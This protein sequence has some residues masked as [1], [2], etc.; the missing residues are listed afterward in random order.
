MLTKVATKP[1][2]NFEDLIE[3]KN[4]LEHFEKTLSEE[5]NS[6]FLFCFLKIKKFNETSNKQNKI[7]L[8]T[9]IYNNYLHEKSLNCLN[10]MNKKKLNEKFTKASEIPYGEQSNIVNESLKEISTVLGY[11]F[12]QYKRTNEW[13]NY[14][15]TTYNL[16]SKPL[17][18]EVYTNIS[19]TSMIEISG[20]QFS[21][22]QKLTNEF[23]ENFFVYFLSDFEKNISS[24]RQ[25]IIGIKEKLNENLNPNIL[26]FIDLYDEMSSTSENE[27]ELYLIT[28]EF[29]FNLKDYIDSFKDKIMNENVKIRMFFNT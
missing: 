18:E 9:D 15:S 11:I 22:V 19:T 4:D 21:K 13:K 20:I 12:Q 5:N 17:F 3:R 29:K 24:I 1:P 26:P 10:L 25:E 16:D 6:K 14:I 7:S 28:K 27:R 23:E 8:F 2:K